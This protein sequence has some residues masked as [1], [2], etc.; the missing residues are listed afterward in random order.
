[1]PENDPRHPLRREMGLS[2]HFLHSSVTVMEASRL[3]RNL[4]PIKNLICSHEITSRLPCFLLSENDFELLQ[5][6]HYWIFGDLL[7]LYFFLERATAGESQMH[8]WHP[9][10]DI[11]KMS[12]LNH[13]LKGI[14]TDIKDAVEKAK[15]SHEIK[16][17]F[18]PVYFNPPSW[19][20]CERFIGACFSKGK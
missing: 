2:G 3:I 14:L 19:S 20:C 7:Q 13:V 16:I 12:L 8:R 1:M 6:K 17:R 18:S 5:Q 10:R 4:C 11:L 9:W 15:I